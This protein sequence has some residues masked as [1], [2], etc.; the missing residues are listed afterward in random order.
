MGDTAKN[1]VQT[2][3]AGFFMPVEQA[4][5]AGNGLGSTPWGADKRR[6]RGRF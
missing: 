2:V 5:H 6:M 3:C 1:P 4:V